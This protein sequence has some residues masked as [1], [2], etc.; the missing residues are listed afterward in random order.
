M[1]NLVFYRSGMLTTI[2]DA[3]RSKLAA[4]KGITTGGFLVPTLARLGNFIVGNTQ[5]TEALEFVLVGPKIF[6]QS[7]PVKLCVVGEC[8]LCINQTPASTYTSYVLSAGDTVDIKKTQTTGYVCIQGG[9][10]VDSVLNSKSVQTRIRVGPN[11]GL[12]FQDG[13]AI[14]VPDLTNTTTYQLRY[15]PKQDDNNIRVIKGP[16]WN[17]FDNPE[18]FFKGHH[19]VTANRNRAA[20]T[21]TSEHKVKYPTEIINSEGNT[22]GCVL[23]SP[24]GNSLPI[25]NDAGSTSGYLKIAVVI[26]ADLEKLIQ[27]PLHSKI[28]FELVDQKSARRAK[29]YMDKLCS[30]IQTQENLREIK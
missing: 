14:T 13:Q 25:L 28:Q 5:D 11:K 3:G 17:K 7:G 30:T 10:S 16:H 9:I 24:D 6:V 27:L 8:D 21:L 22:L 1:P 26:S 18:D 20:I 15:V 23:I 2:Q 12:P 4:T 19:V 29:Q